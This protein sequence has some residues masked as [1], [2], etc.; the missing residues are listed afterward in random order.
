MTKRCTHCRK[1]K[2]LDQ[3]NKRSALKLGV[4]AYCQECARKKAINFYHSNPLRQNKLGIKRKYNLSDAQID[5]WEKN[6]FGLCEMC[7]KPET[8]KKSLSV[9]HCHSTGKFRGLLCM[10][11][12]TVSYPDDIEMLQKRVSY[13][14]KHSGI[15]DDSGWEEW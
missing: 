5:H 10:K 9:D 3:F 13:L 6:R 15:I 12:N 1:T 7:G 14:K 11:C 4:S 8:V 2:T